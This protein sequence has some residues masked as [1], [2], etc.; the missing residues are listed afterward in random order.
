MSFEVTFDGVKYSCVNCT[1][2]CSCKN[3]RVFLSYF[4][5]MR[6][7]DYE[8]YIETS[9]SEYGHVLALMNG[10]CGLVEN[11]L[12]KIQIEKNYDSKP[13]MCKLFPFSFMVKWNGEMLL[14]LK[15]YCNGI[16]TGKTGKRTIKHAV[17]CCEELYHDQLSELSVSGAE[18]SEKTQLDENTKIYWEEREELGKYIFKTKKFDSFSEKYFEVFSKNADDVDKLKLKNNSFDF[19]TKTK[20]FR[21][22][23]VLRYM[24]ELNKR[25]HFR[26]MSFKKEV[27]DLITVGLEISDYD[28]L[29]RGEGAIDSKILLN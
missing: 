20:K 18:T 1:Y 8:K 22:K 28:N 2:C 19:D 21:E 5:M 12:C 17:D 29:F 7:K 27:D 4:D 23:E 26:K 24:Q 15:H 3:W 11:N 25:E 9:N 6:L 13:A 16:Q 10:K 14:I